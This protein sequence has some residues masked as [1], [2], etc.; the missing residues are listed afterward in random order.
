MIGLHIGFF[1]DLKVSIRS[2]H[3]LSI[4]FPFIGASD[5]SSEFEA[6]ADT[7]VVADGHQELDPDTDPTVLPRW[8]GMGRDF[9]SWCVPARCSTLSLLNVQL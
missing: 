9:R 1:V 8:A 2:L 3:S 6:A 7:D 5:W 4:P